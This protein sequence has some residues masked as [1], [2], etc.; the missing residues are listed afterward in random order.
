M[1]TYLLVNDVNVSLNDF[2]QKYIGNVL[3]GIVASL[4]FSN[5]KIN[6][7]LNK[8][9]LKIFSGASGKLKSLHL[10]FANL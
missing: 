2:T 6:F 10:F 4:G 1:K 5:G 7:Y 8:D 3:R 9:E